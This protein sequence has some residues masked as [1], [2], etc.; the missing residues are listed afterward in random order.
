MS[1]EVAGLLAWCAACSNGF[2]SAKSVDAPTVQY[3]SD[4]SIDAGSALD[5]SA[6]RGVPVACSLVQA[7]LTSPLACRADWSCP[8]VGVY[9]LSCD[10]PDGGGLYC[11]CRLNRDLVNVGAIQICGT[12]IEGLTAT[13]AQL[14][15]WT[16]LGQPSDGGGS[17]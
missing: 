12:S 13:A 9:S 15:G 11:T 10:Q 17:Q 1:R 8:S 6:A 7:N 2:S 3:P 5:G 16:F 14:C 4:G